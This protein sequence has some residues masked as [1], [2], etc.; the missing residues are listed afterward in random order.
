VKT[1][2]FEATAP[3]RYR[4]AGE[5][6]FETVPLIWAESKAE[7]DDAGDPQ[8]DLAEVTNVDS[9]GLALVIEWIRLAREHGRHLRLENLPDTLLALARISELDGLLEGRPERQGSSS[10]KSSSG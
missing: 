6:S 3:G 2:L 8:I 4:V 1:C 5:L 7:L 9:A 10:S